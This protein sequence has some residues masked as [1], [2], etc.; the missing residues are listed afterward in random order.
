M[1]AGIHLNPG[2]TGRVVPKTFF[3]FNCIV[4]SKTE[5][6]DFL[7]KYDVQIAAIQETKLT[8]KSKDPSFQG[9]S[10]VRRDRLVGRGE[11]LA[12]LIHDSVRY[13]HLNTTSLIAPNDLTLE[14]QG[15][16]TF[17]NK[18]IIIN[19]YIPPVSANARYNPDLSKILEIDGNCLIL[20]DLNA[21]NATWD[22]SFS[23]DRGD[24]IVQQIEISNFLGAK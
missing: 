9:Y 18:I 20:G 12:F 16:S 4:S 11:G 1:C 17:I 19:I 6:Q 8:T 24:R 22:S 14:L 13:T 2:P 3:E 23:D 10:I 15:I 21:H 5:L 7:L